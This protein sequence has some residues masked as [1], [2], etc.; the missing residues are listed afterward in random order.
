MTKTLKRYT[1]IKKMRALEVTEDNI[2]DM[3]Q[4]LRGIYVNFN[5]IPHADRVIS[6]LID[7]RSEIWHLQE[8]EE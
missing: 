5:S 8:A 1:K 2:G 6:L 3:I 4:L 7:A